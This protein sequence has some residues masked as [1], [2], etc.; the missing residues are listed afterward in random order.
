MT[1]CE[2]FLYALYNGYGTRLTQSSNVDKMLNEQ[3]L[4]QIYG[5]THNLKEETIQCLWFP[6]EQVI[7]ASFLKPVV[8]EHGRKGSYNHTIL[9]TLNDYFKLA[10]PS[11]ILEKHFIKNQTVPPD[12]LK[13]LEVK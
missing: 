10:P 4:R 9:L 8:D 13:P 3:S 6:D 11:L 2:H 5:L 1:T 7:T 12:M